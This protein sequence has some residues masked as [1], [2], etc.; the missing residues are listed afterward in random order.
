MMCS[1]MRLSTLYQDLTAEE[2]AALAK[3]VGTDPGYIW[4]L[5][6]RWRGKRA[7]IGFMSKLVAAEPRLSIADMSE[8]FAEPV[9]GE[10]A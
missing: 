9:E 4:Q 1:I 7:S 8:E 2:R 6:T 10:R 3:K 5:A